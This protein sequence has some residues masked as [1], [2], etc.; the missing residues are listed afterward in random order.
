MGASTLRCGTVTRR[1]TSTCAMKEVCVRSLKTGSRTSSTRTLTRA[2]ASTPSRSGHSPHASRKLPKSS[3]RKTT[4]RWPPRSVSR[5][6]Q[7]SE[8]FLVSRPARTSTW[9]DLTGAGSTRDAELW[10]RGKATPSPQSCERMWA[11]WHT[12]VRTSAPLLGI[13]ETS[14]ET[15]IAQPPLLLPATTP[16]RTLTQYAPLLQGRRFTLHP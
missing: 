6:H 8:R 13:P 2:T 11:H 12:W 7:S 16:A 9:A 4:S 5:A 15:A 10:E 14:V 3:P 1:A